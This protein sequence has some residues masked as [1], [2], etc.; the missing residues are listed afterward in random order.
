MVIVVSM[1]LSIAVAVAAGE[2]VGA[3]VP[4]LLGV[5]LA[6]VLAWLGQPFSERAVG[7]ALAIATLNLCLVLPEV[8][9]RAVGFRYESGI[10]FG[11]PNTLQFERFVPDETL[12]W[13][14]SP[15]SGSV[16]S[17]GFFGPEPAVPCPPNTT[18]LLFLGDSCTVRGYPEIAVD[19]LNAGHADAAGRFECVNLALNGYTTHQG[20]LLAERH[21]DRLRPALAFVYFGW[22]DHWRAIGTIDSEKKVVVDRSFSGRMAEALYRQVRLLQAAKAFA[23]RLTGGG[24]TPFLDATRVPAPAYRANLEAIRARLTAAGA[25]VVFMTAPSSHEKVGFPPE[26]AAKGAVP[27][28]ATGLALHREYNDI[29]RAVA[30]EKGDALLD[31]AA[32]MSALPDLRPLFLAD[33]IHFTESGRA[34]VATRVA[35]EIAALASAPR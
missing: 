24:A 18:R 28:V 35:A 29:V 21:A 31:L 14:A 22:N 12:F 26:L 13:H 1:A 2:S 32:E 10:E 9:L 20:R 34:W 3:I 27:D 11:Y 8:A 33:G 6:V 15:A 7:P 4:A 16:N 23:I 25:R 30:K 19:L 5:V 17:L